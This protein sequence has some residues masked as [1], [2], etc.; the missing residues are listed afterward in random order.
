M[1]N[2][3]SF[4]LSLSLTRKIKRLIYLYFFS[5]NEIIAITHFGSE[6]KSLSPLDRE[7]MIS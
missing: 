4:F 3:F 1:P 6:G 7:V 5:R 2:T